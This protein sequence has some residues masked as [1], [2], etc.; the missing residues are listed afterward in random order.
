VLRGLVT[1]TLLVLG[2]ALAAEACSA[3]PDSEPAPDSPNAQATRV[4][5]TAAA[6]VQKIIANNSTPTPLAAPTD[7]PTPT[8]K[9][10]IWWTEARS[11]VGESRKIQGTIVGTRPSPEG[12]VVLEVGQ[13]YPDPTGLAVMLQSAWG[14]ASPGKTVCVAGRITLGEGRATLQ[15][16]DATSIEVVN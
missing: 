5:R 12:G 14:P 1:L 7:T 11:H 3:P 9:D 16:R 8:C 2:L 13:P 6:A 4:R 15:V 10:A